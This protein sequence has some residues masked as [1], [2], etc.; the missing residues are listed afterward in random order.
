MRILVTGAFGNIGESTLQQLVKQGHETR[1][2]DVK[3]QANEKVAKKYKDEVE[4]IWGDIRRFDDVV[5]AVDGQE[6][7]V[8]LAFVIASDTSVTGISSEDDPE[9][10]REINVG[11]TEN[12][13]KASEAQAK[14]PTIVFASSFNVFGLTQHLPPPRTASDPVHAVSHYTQHKIECEEMLKTAS[15]DW[16]VLRFAVVSPLRMVPSADMFDPPLKNR[17]E[18]VHTRD[19]GLACANAVASEEAK[20]KILLIGGGPRCQTTYGDFLGKM[21][22]TMGLGRLPEKAFG[23]EPYGMD[24]LDT[25]ES[26]R[27][28][29]YQHHTIDDY[30]D[31][32]KS[33][34]GY[35]RHLARIFRPIARWYLLRQ[36]PYYKNR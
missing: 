20:G 16:V 25:E 1:C 29:Q 5:A 18:F 31:E 35:R 34:V 3:T 19:V 7:I 14:S 23:T 11:G 8:H 36:S 2:F 27:L 30:V 12:I 21:L 9:W 17:M 33:I 4:V 13:V 6:A 24:W 28:L 10:A 32:M 22:E 15:L 26:Q